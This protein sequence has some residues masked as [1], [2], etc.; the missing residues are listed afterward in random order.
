MKLIFAFAFSLLTTVAVA[1]VP[2]V[3]SSNSTEVCMTINSVLPTVGKTSVCY[4]LSDDGATDLVAAYK[5]MCTVSNDAPC[6]PAQAF[7]T[8]AD[9][10]KGVVNGVVSNYLKS[11]A[12]P[13]AAPLSVAH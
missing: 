1:Q 11:N 10:L 13:K 6:T 9:T 4:T 7:A 3:L 2:T 5:A 8:M 12:T